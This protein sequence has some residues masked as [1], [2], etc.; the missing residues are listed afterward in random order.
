MTA[1]Y[2]PPLPAM[3]VA[4]RAVGLDQ[5]LALPAFAHLSADD[6][7]GVLEGF[8]R[9]AADVIAP[10]DEIGDREGA[11]RD[12]DTGDVHLPEVIRVAF[13]RWVADGWSGLGASSEHGGAGLP[14]VVALAAE[15]MLASANMA[16]SLN[17]MLT[18]G[19]TELLAR[20]GTEAQQRTYL[21]KLVS[22]EWTGTMN[23][24][25]PEAGSDLRGVRARAVP[26]DD[27]RWEISGTKIFITWGEHDLADNIVH[28]VLARTPGA[29]EG[30]AG[31]SLFLVPR[32]MVDADGSVGA[33]NR[34]S[35]AAIERKLGIH[36]SPTCVMVFDRAVGEL[37]GSECG[38]LAAMF[39]MMNAAR[40]SVGLEGLGIAERA[41]QQALQHARERLQGRAPGVTGEVSS[42]II[43]HPDVRRNLMLIATAVDAMR[44]L[45][46]T[47]ATAADL[48]RHHPDSDVR[49]A[50]AT[51]GDL[52]TPMAKAWSTDE[53]VRASSIALQVHGGMGYVEESGVAQRLRDARVAP[54]YEGTNG[55]QAID[56]ASRKVRRDGGQGVQ[57]LL[58][59]LR[60]SAQA[61]E[62]VGMVPQAVAILD[63]A[64]DAFDAATRWL[65][66][67]TVEEDWLAAASPYLDLA[68]LAT[69]GGLLARQLAWVHEHGDPDAVALVA[70]RFTFFAAERLVQVPALLETVRS[71]AARLPSSDAIV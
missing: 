33:R 61:V 19:A 9:F 24:T 62:R 65:V 67:T 21:A 43:E 14:V 63:R 57:E 29:P 46:Y 17:A 35:C 12:P 49:A 36:A 40:R 26:R 7:D 60:G 30:S 39:T 1:A 20:W 38:G 59:E 48:A 8:G 2:V 18:Q 69:C 25:E 27:G 70:A 41:F 34:V 50:A 3:G 58:A 66:D 6:V 31:I 56:L 5:V 15:E 42:P 64:L 13:K 54:I 32:H 52:L 45:L 71:G 22:S 16:L 37:V 10:T 4:L 53:G 44:A 23:M 28:F 47:T 11:T 55:I 51:R 68:S